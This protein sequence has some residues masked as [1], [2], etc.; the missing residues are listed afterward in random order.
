MAIRNIGTTLRDH[1]LENKE[2]N[3]THLV[4][5]EKP[6]NEEKEGKTTQKG[7]TYSYISDGAFDI[8]WDDLSKD[9]EGNLNGPQTYYASKL[10]KVGSVSETIE[11]KG[12][13]LSM[14][15]DAAAL[16]S[17]LSTP[18]LT[19]QVDSV[20]GN[21]ITTSLGNFI[22]EGF[23]EGDKIL[24]SS[25]NTAAPNRGKYVIIKNF[26]DN[27][28]KITY[29]NGTESGANNTLTPTTSGGDYVITLT[30][31]ELNS[32]ILSKG[33]NAYTTYTNRE[34]M[35]YKAILDVDTNA[36]IGDPFLLFKGI[37]QNGAIKENPDKT[38]SVTWTLASHWGDFSRVS[39]RLTVD[40]AHR[41]L[42]GSGQPDREATVRE[43]YADDLGFAHA[44]QSI[45]VM[46]LYNDIEIS[47]KQVDIN[48][49]WPGGK[50]IREVENVV[51]RRTD[52]AF[53]LS[54][55]YLPVIYGVQKTDAIPIFVDTSNTNAAEIFVAYAICEGPVAGLLDIYID[56]NSG[57]CVDKADFD[58]RSGGGD[59][60][61]LQCKGRM[62]RGDALAGYNASTGSA[63]NF[64]LLGEDFAYYNNF[65]GMNRGGGRYYASLGQVY[66]GAS[67]TVTENA[68][69]LLHEKTHTITSPI[70]GH[71][72][73]HA[74]KPFQRANPTLLN[75]AAANGFKIQND[76]F[77]ASNRGKYWGANHRVLDTAYTVG[78]FTIAPGETSIP[79][80]DFIV[81]GKG[82][83]CF[84]YDR[85]FNATN[86]VSADAT[87]FNIGDTVALRTSSSAYVNSNDAAASSVTI[88]DKWTF[89]DIDGTILQRFL[90]DYNKDIST[91]HYMEKTGG[92]KWY[93]APSI[94]TDDITSTVQSPSKT[95][96]TSSAAGSSGGVN[97]VVD[98]TA[99]FNQ[100]MAAV[101]AGIGNEGGHLAFSGVGRLDLEAG[102]FADLVYNSTTGTF[103][104]IASGA[105]TTG[106]LDSSV[107]EVFIKDAIIL[108]SAN[109]KPDNFYVGHAI[110]LTRF[111]SAGVPT[112]QKRLIKSYKNA[113]NVALV[114]TEWNAGYFPDSGD[115]YTISIGKPDVRVTINPA[116]QLLDYL[117]SERYGRGLDLSNDIDLESFKASARACDTRSNVTVAT[118][119][120][121]A[122]AVDDIY[123]YP[124]SGALLFRGTV[125][126]VTT[127]KV[128]GTAN[129]FKEVV[130]KDVIGKLGKKWNSWESFAGNQII[131]DNGSLWLMSSSG[132]Q[133]TTVPDTSG[134]YQTT[135]TAFNLTK[136]SGTGPT[137]LSLDISKQSANGNPLVKSW[138]SYGGAQADN[139]SFVGSGYS[140]YDSD[141]IKYWKYIG[142]DSN[143]QR[144]VTRHQMNQSVATSNPIFDNINLM[145]KQFNGI[146]RYSNG[147]YQLDIKSRT[148][149]S[150]D[151]REILDES[152][153]IGSISLKDGGVKKAHNSISTSIKDPQT[154]FESRSVSFFNSTYLKQDKN[155]PKKGNYGMPGIT[156][157]FNARFN[158][159]QM[160][161]ES[162]YGMTVSFKMAPKGYLLLPG[163][164]I[165]LN[166]SRFG[167]VDKEFRIINLVVNTDC[168]INVTADEH[169]NDAYLI[170]NLSK[171]SLGGDVQVGVSPNRNAPA[172][173]TN[174]TATTSGQKGV[175]TLNWT[176]STDFNTN[177]QATEIYS[178]TVNDRAHASFA[179][180]ATVREET[181]E[182]AV[183]NPNETTKFYWIR[184]VL[185]IEVPVGRAGGQTITRDLGSAYA[186]AG[187]TAG[188][189]GT[190]PEV[191][192][193]E[194]GPG[195]WNIGVSALPSS[196]SQAQSRW[197]DGTGDQPTTQVTDDQ[198]WFFTGTESAPSGQKVWIYGGSSWT[199]QT[200]VIRGELLV[201]GT[202]TTGEIADG[203][204]L[205][206]N[207][208]QS[209]A[210]GRFG[211]IVAAI[212]TFTQVDTDVLNA[213]SV[214][215]REVQVFPTG[216]TPPTISGTTL[217]GAGIDLK[218]DG[219]M[220]IGNAATNKYMFWDQ[221]E[222]TMTFR[223]TLDVDD[224]TGSSAKF[225]TLMAE[226]ATIGTLNTKMLDSDAIVTRDIRVG[227]SVEVNAGSF[228]S[229]TEYY[230][231]DLGNTTQAQWNTAAG[232]SG[233]VYNLGS[234]F[235]SSLGNPGTGTGKARNRTTVAKIAGA[236]LTGAGAHLNAD[237]D[238]YVGNAA[239]NKYMFWDQSAGTMTLRGELNA[240]DIT[241]GT[242]SANKIDVNNLAAL[243][244]NLGDVTAGTLKGG[245]L[246]DA[247][248]APGT[249]ESGAFFNLGVG[250][251]LVGNPDKYIWWD[252]TALKLNGVEISD[253]TLANSSGVATETYVNTAISNLLDTAPTTLDTLNELAAALGDDPNFATSVST[254][255]GNKVSTTSNQALSANANALEISGS[256]ITLTRGDGS[257]DTV[258]TPNTNTFRPIHD[259]PVDGAT[260]TSISSN[261]A[262]D[263]V[264][265]AVP[266]G[267]IFTDTNSQR[268]IHDTPVNGATT[269][270][271]SSNWAFDNVKTAV[272][273]SAVFTDTNTFRPIH[274]TPVDGATTTSISSNWAFDNVKTAVPT[275]AVFT[276]T[277]TV[278]T[279]PN[280]T[281]D[282][283]SSGDGATTIGSNK[284]TFAKMQDIATD[285]FM[286]RT[287][288][289]SGDAKALSVSE[290]R[291]ML[292]VE[293]GATA[294]QTAAQ[295][296]A[297]LKTVDVNGTAGIN[298]GTF[299][300]LPGANI[301]KFY[302]NAVLTDSAS[303][304]SFIAELASD[305]GCFGNNQVTLKVQWSYA[306]SSDLVTGHATI[307]TLELAGCTIETWGGTYK[308]VRITR[309]NTGTGGHMVVEYNDQSSS[310]APGWREIWTSESDG[311]GSGLDA[312]KLD[313]QQGTH[314]LAYGN[315]TGT[316]TIPSGNQI[317][318][319]TAD[320]G[321]TN[322]HTG[323][324]LN[325]NTTNL[326]LK[327]TGGSVVNMTAGN[328]LEFAGTG[329]AS[330]SRSATKIT[331]AVAPYTATAPLSIVAATKVVSIA[332]SSTSANGYLSSTDW[333]SFNS[334]ISNSATQ[335]SNLYIRNGS[336]TIYLRDTNNISSMIHQNSDVFYVLRADA[337]DD[338]TWT[339]YTTADA[340]NGR[341]PL[342]MN[343]T[344][345]S[346]S[347]AFGSHNITA[348]GYTV[349]HSGNTSLL[350]LGNTATT[351]LAGNT[352]LLQIGT[353]STTALAGN[354]T[355][356][357]GT[358]TNVQVGNGLSVSSS[359][360]T[361]TISLGSALLENLGAAT[362]TTID[363]DILNANSV[364]IARDLRGGNLTSAAIPTGTNKGFYLNADGSLMIGNASRH[365][366]MDTSGNVGITNLTV[367]D[368]TGDVT[369]VLSFGPI[370]NTLA[371]GNNVGIDLIS[372]PSSAYAYRPVVSASGT[373]MIQNRDQMEVALQIRENTTTS[374]VSLGNVTVSTAGV[375]YGKYGFFNPSVTVVATSA[376]AFVA[377]TVG[378]TV[379]QGSLSYIVASVSVTNSTTQVIGY[380]N[381]AGTNFS[382]GSNL[383]RG[384]NSP[385]YETVGTIRVS[386]EDYNYNHPVPFAVQGGLT[387]ISAESC[388]VR[389][390]ITKYINPSSSEYYKTSVGN[391][392]VYDDCKNVYGTAL[393]VR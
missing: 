256:V 363:T 202:V 214:I 312:D 255:L 393:L 60:V 41:A 374:A 298:A 317:I 76:Y 192:D 16:G 210:G 151:S 25:V 132:G 163:S 382:T 200:E 293:N 75:K 386:S 183:P 333:N 346:H 373:I 297:A 368:I 17:S 383:T 130:F 104:G 334:R 125:E 30:S 388:D 116:M 20:Y 165:K 110:T 167:W 82:V 173:P 250:K 93:M 149:V 218:Q 184:H 284:V 356:P 162:R 46:A 66:Q 28:T 14:T 18:L 90:T 209:S 359:T 319:W 219:D 279:H 161:D 113:G 372:I 271:I 310:Y 294:D 23:R 251:F 328:T 224:I 220:Y 337:A 58:L 42:D 36:M 182:A 300:G 74:G 215:A 2:F 187:A 390:L 330:V 230:I 266:S 252:G 7:H 246:P 141:D 278:Y 392:Y 237:G 257:T 302:N 295:I 327:V 124:A 212:G 77:D 83:E 288:S 201:D 241:A 263:N 155:I 348:G 89:I 127:R 111:D 45:N 27:G 180:V 57:I 33:A 26:R 140:L 72:Q 67:G 87:N 129:A 109:S 321:A 378:D 61:D 126:S 213:N 103:T 80:M 325:T 352:S 244:A 108:N 360:T 340:A 21:C 253:A 48:G 54:P 134:S 189:T 291:T 181:F 69:G 64:S 78:K 154:K 260:T 254:S 71:F 362:F 157:Y 171:P 287:A 259:T 377:A 32:L 138:V 40:E 305:Y 194:R 97:V 316:P 277:N 44:N 347:V 13:S 332:Q 79:E 102:S 206:D 358:V 114:D 100:I 84:N 323:N 262:F 267:A 65:N 350:T 311:A 357:A 240:D 81:R 276:D 98:N 29:D 122:I 264:K 335:S 261:W 6:T 38:S 170:K 375:N 5:F 205:A 169:N 306:G 50:R 243:S 159:N 168:T 55:K 222:G 37:I 136:V 227:P 94:A 322:I 92:H 239:T 199:E 203:T 158:I 121:N 391:F 370:N 150:F 223:G 105:G 229:Y 369:E 47:Y 49:G 249:G 4:K 272:P 248:D 176:N 160:L 387:R 59:T 190:A 195:R 186:P 34:V 341:W 197:N 145:L 208:D 3:Y 286:G 361:P 365:L 338:V 120:S 73:F 329:I 12:S 19:F 43:E 326:N 188:V 384:A 270:S 303:T 198:A 112:I 133:Q 353:S 148:P 115:S 128:E 216:G 204:I 233:V 318:D 371:S 63:N 119:T 56:G 131:W 235:T 275:S 307:G 85:S 280:H 304:A 314:Y 185:H 285:T 143:D 142:W 225:A 376:A 70:D 164:I 344:N 367:N 172:P 238:F 320:Q 354:T 234:I 349:H 101:L 274:D 379:T 193:G 175:V 366:T 231:T 95:T 139:G 217:A 343:L 342:T 389:L 156:N 107:E 258:T 1:L 11:A 232:T 345:A 9:A 8:V 245:N 123:R 226:V 309:P 137:S 144:N 10:T 283:T 53:N 268:P 15:L 265:T 24:I 380:Y 146:L 135:S 281:G 221:S 292:N 324:Y 51:E 52:L 236:T 308:H 91:A 68:T 106:A 269:T 22:E 62:D 153:I 313:G 296:L 152:D 177:F 196:S 179:K 289:G 96:I 381:Y 31:E 273:T 336:P 315:F 351:A 207:I 118:A 385:A 211:E 166:Y 290:A 282:V 301:P 35:I 191:Q 228:V 299:D 86:T 117:T 339:T 364:I 331:V 242:I 147:K 39:G 174:L 88:T 99:L 247:D 178:A 355:I